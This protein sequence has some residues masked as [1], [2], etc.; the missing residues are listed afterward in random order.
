M[1]KSHIQQGKSK[2]TDKE[3]IERLERIVENQNQWLQNLT[4]CLNTH[5]HQIPVFPIYRYFPWF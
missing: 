5:Q 2:I 1:A 3:R 4:Q